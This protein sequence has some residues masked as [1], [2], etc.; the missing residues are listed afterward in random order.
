MMT[1]EGYMSYM[2]KGEFDPETDTMARGWYPEGLSAFHVTPRHYFNDS[3]GIYTWDQGEVIPVASIDPAFAEGGDN[4]LLT[5]GRYGRVI[6][7]TPYGK[8]YV[9]Y[10]KPFNGLQLEQQIK[11]KKDNGLVMAHEVM[12][13]LKVL[14][15]RPEWFVCDTTGNGIMI[16]DTLKV[17]FGDILGI[18][19]GSAATERKILDEDTMTAEERY[20]GVTAE[21]AFAFSIWLQFGYIKIAPIMDATKLIAQA[22]GRKYSYGGRGL[23]HLQ[24]KADFKSET[25]GMSPDEYDSTI[26]LPH[27][28]RVRQSQRAAMLPDHPSAMARDEG[29]GLDNIRSSV[30]DS[31]QFYDTT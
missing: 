13:Y 29:R 28:I 22:T 6:G 8:K 19:W 24:S 14:Q 30:V 18:Q 26:M 17:I 10:P 16:H 7:F 21:M 5:T 15:V 11:I 25:G 31:L 27:L 20:Y 2:A 1:Y 12:N 4:P 23:I 9:P 3:V